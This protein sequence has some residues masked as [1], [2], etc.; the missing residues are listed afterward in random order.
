MAHYG[1]HRQAEHD[2]ALKF[3]GDLCLTS[4]GS[5]VIRDESDFGSNKAITSLALPDLNRSISDGTTSSGSVGSGKDWEII[6]LLFVLVET[7][8]LCVTR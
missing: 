7:V 8:A 4:D 2:I 5:P 3:G 1:L 6:D